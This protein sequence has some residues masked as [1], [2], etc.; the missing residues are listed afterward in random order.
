VAR[1]PLCLRKGALGGD[2]GHPDWINDAG[3]VVSFSQIQSDQNVF[4]GHAFLWRNGV[5]TDLETADGD[6]DSESLCINAQGQI[7]GDSFTFGGPSHG[8]IWE[9]GAP[10]V[11]SN[12]L[13]SPGATMSDTEVVPIGVCVPSLATG[14]GGLRPPGSSART[15]CI[16]AA[17][18][19]ALW[20][21]GFSNCWKS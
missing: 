20:A 10:A 17:N 2:F 6:P 21:E 12:T 19:R 3:E 1:V 4:V 8:V 18:E 9:N 7:V 5:M 15:F 13:I 11:Y 16:C 14:V